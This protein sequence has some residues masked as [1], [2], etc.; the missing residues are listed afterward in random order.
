M[1]NITYS[2]AALAVS[3]VEVCKVYE[4][5]DSRSGTREHQFQINPLLNSLFAQANGN[6]QEA[7]VWKE[8]RKGPGRRG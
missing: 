1:G 2:C 7:L 3:A 4:L 6:D 8:A 5:V